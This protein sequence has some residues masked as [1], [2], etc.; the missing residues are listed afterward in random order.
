ML[1]KDITQY[2]EQDI[3]TILPEKKH[4]LKTYGEAELWLHVFSTMSLDGIEWYAKHTSRF[5]RGETFP[6][7]HWAEGF[8]ENLNKFVWN[9]Y[10]FATL[11]LQ[12][13]LRSHIPR[14]QSWIPD[15]SVGLLQSVL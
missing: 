5:T 7:R 14:A 10:N 1:I 12:S 2:M 6:G 11:T 15:S 4:A 8:T 9:V 3:S 13:L